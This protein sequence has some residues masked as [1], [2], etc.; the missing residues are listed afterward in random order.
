MDHAHPVPRSRIRESQASHPDL[1]T[2]RTR[3]RM[4]TRPLAPSAS[5]PPSASYHP[6]T[7][8]SAPSH[9]KRQTTNPN[10]YAVVEPPY[11]EPNG[12]RP[13]PGGLPRYIAV[14]TQ[15]DSDHALSQI[16]DIHASVAQ[17]ATISRSSAETPL[18]S[19]AWRMKPERDLQPG[20]QQF[21]KTSFSRHDCLR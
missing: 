20:S 16:I 15:L 1:Q 19:S 17:L 4:A 6:S 12:T 2:L 13:E 3:R 8:P 7:G 9:Q 21:V 18:E 11:V 14:P 5:P 10:D